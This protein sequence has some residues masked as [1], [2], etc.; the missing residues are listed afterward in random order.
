ML[1]ALEKQSYKQQCKTLAALGVDYL[2][3]FPDL[4]DYQVTAADGHF[5]QHACH[6]EKKDKGKV[7]AAGSIYA[8]NLR[9]G[10]L[11]PVCY[12]IIHL[13]RNILR[14]MK[15]KSARINYLY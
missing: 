3:Q 14:F 2:D 7:F 9:Y 13:N 4:D 10:L 6:T 12:Y 15:F 8:L 1:K 5:I 11:S